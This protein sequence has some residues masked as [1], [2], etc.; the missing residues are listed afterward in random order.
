[1][2]IEA[3]VVLSVSEKTTVRPQMHETQVKR[4]R[5]AK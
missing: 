1:M 3:E 2:S 5:C 4:K